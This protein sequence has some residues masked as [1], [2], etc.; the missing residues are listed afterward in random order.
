MTSAKMC[1]IATRDR[2]TQ[3]NSLT[4]SQK[5]IHHNWRRRITQLSLVTLLVLGG[6]GGSSDSGSGAAVKAS[7][8]NIVLIVMDDVGI[9]QWKL[10]GYGGVTPPATPNIDAIAR[11]GVKFH[12]MW[13]MPAC[14]NSRAALFTGRYPFRTQ[15]YTALGTNDLA[16]SMVNPNEITLPQLLKQRGYKS[17]LFGKYHLGI[18]SNDPYGLGMVHAAGFDYFDGWLDITGD[19]S[20]ID[21]TAGGVSPPGTWSCGFVRDAADGGADQGACYAADNTCSVLTI[22][23]AEAPGRICRDSGGIFDPNQPCV[24]PVPSYINFS[25]LSGHYVSP[26]VLNNEDGTVVQVPPTDI[27]ARTYRGT[28]PVDSAINWIKSQPANQPWMVALAFATVHTPVMQPPS[29]LLPSTEPDSSNVDCTQTVGQRILANQMEE[30][31]DFEIGRFLVASGLASM[32]PGGKLNY[33]PRKTNT[34]IVLITDN[35]SNGAVVKLPF[36]SFRAKSTAYQTGVWVPAIVS[37]PEVNQPGREVGAMVNIVDLYQLI[38]EIVGIDVHQ[39]VPRTVDAASMLPYLKNPAQRSI[40]KSNFTEIGTNLQANGA[41]NGP[42]QYN[43]TTCT[44]IAP[45]KGVCEDNNGIWWGAGATDPST[46]GIPSQGLTLCCDVAVWQHDHGQ[47]VSTD[48]YPYRADAIR[49]DSYKI[50]VNNYNSYDAGTD[51]CAITTSTEFYQINEHTPIPKL[52]SAGSDLLTSGIPLTA[53]QQKNYDGLN[54]QLTTLLASQPTC[55]GDI[56]LDGVVNDLDVDQWTM[57][58]ALS[59][60]LSSWAD[61]NLDGLTNNTD[62]N[63]IEQHMGP[64]PT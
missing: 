14:S 20:S 34:W 49:N 9:D 28:E 19:P 11:G 40:R 29:Q 63:I 61:L 3:L 21:S 25:T 42:C 55:I 12:N 10:F 51:A 23:G 41:I 43:T 1:T 36:D 37:G 62:L 32:G 24:N 47:T 64:C 13:A 48:I 60:G 33:H 5:M 27:R 38:G 46:A 8:P 31:L 59:L 56:N 18:Q 39:T 30:A 58:Q 57:L 4:P 15:V 45:S 50:V 26:L 16:N 6:C 35:G 17:A 52:D 2:N 54:A 44:Q 7:T 22:T 53:V